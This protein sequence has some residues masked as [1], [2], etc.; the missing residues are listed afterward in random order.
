MTVPGSNLLK[1]AARLIRLQEVAYYQDAGRTTNAIGIDQTV[2]QPPVTIKGSVQAVPL[3]AYQELGLDFGKNYVTLYTQTP[4][5]GVERDVSGDV[6][7]YNSK[8]YQ[9]KSPTD[10]NAQD[11]W[12]AVLAV[13]TS[14]GAPIIRTYVVTPDPDPNFVVNP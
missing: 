8:V 2:Y 11:G 9:V 6:F 14:Y 1:R 4:L 7:T 3:S 13:Q 12:N 10:W 5:I